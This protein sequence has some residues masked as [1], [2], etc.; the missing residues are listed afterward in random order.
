MDDA[1]S[2]AIAAATRNVMAFFA[3]PRTHAAKPAC[4]AGLVNPPGALHPWLCSTQPT[5]IKM[6]DDW[7]KDERGHFI[8][9]P[10]VSAQPMTAAGMTV[11]LRLTYAN[12]GDPSQTPSGSLQLAM[13]GLQAAELVQGLI[14]ALDNLDP[15]RGSA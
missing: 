4:R 15:P 12:P 1:G 3:E 8:V 2:V 5:E 11:C 10:L 7:D 14:E 9:R 6:L 13:T